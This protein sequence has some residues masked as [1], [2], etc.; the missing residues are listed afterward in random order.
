MANLKSDLSALKHGY[1][2]YSGWLISFLCTCVGI[3]QSAAGGRLRSHEETINTINAL[4]TH[5]AR[6]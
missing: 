3:A 4:I 5:Y 1:G 6:F 2:S